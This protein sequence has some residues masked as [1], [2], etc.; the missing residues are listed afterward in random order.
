VKKK[1][2]IRKQTTKQKYLFDF[3][4]YIYIYISFLI[5]SFHSE[6]LTIYCV[7]AYNIVLCSIT[8]FITKLIV[9]C[10]FLLLCAR[11]CGIYLF[12]F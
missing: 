9:V 5:V 4:I 10:L 8:L 12:F 2:T 3:L 6:N 1:S 7:R 11:A